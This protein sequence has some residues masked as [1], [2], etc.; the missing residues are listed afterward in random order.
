[1]V[2][3]YASATEKKIINHDAAI[4]RIDLK[5]RKITIIIINK[6][7]MNVRIS[8]DNSLSVIAIIGD[9]PVNEK[10]RELSDAT[11]SILFKIVAGP[12]EYPKYI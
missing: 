11:F 4:A 7:G 2:K 1:M 10:I 6:I 8:L 12:A 5:V 9:F 3:L